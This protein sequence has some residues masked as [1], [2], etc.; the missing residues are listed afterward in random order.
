[1]DLSGLIDRNAA[2]APDKPAIRCAGTT[3]TYADFAVRIA[4]A[5]R[6]LK[7]ELGIGRG[8]RVAI[9]SLNHPDYLVLLYACA[10]LGAMLVPLNWRL[11]VPEQVFILSDASVKAL[12]VEQDSAAVIAPLAQ[13]LP[14]AR[15]VGL[16]FTPDGGV[17]LDTL[18][19]SGTGD[20]RNPHV[21]LTSPL[22]IV[23]T[24]GTTGR[25]KGAVL[26]QEALVWNA[27]M[28]Q[29]MHD[30]TAADHV[31][32][33]LP[34]FHV[35][36]LN[37]QTTPALQLGATVTLH[38]R[39]APDATLDAL[40]RDKPTLTVLV[41]ATMQA[42]IEHPRWSGTDISSLRALT[43]GSTQVPQG[44]ADAFTKRNI[45]VL[46]VYGSTETCPLAVYTRLNGDQRD[47]STG[48]PGLVCDARIVND[49][50]D[51]VAA[52]VAGEVIV[53]GPNVFFEYWGHAA[54]T[55]EALREGWYYSG[56][57]GTR[58]ADGHFFIHDR[59][60]NMIISGGEN[61]Y[62][63]EIE[64]VLIAHPDVAEAAVIGRV[65]PKWQEVPV[66]YVVRRIGCV[67]NARA[68]EAH[69]LGQLARFK[70]P[71]EYVF[72][73]SLPRNAMGKVQHFRLREMERA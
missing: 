51:E 7:S 56:D 58:D 28:S 63:A 36:G 73:E 47:G 34:L 68:L 45:P 13:A 5:A 17:S 55:T 72:V 60:K 67:I 10:R 1:M 59:K 53:R 31:L 43:T 20:S 35:G 48:L 3:L 44:L 9:L 19:T 64:R 2:F 30:M 29:H 27:V 15:I 11:A 21:D 61:I 25:P 37:I 41:P 54:A 57:I 24:S 18:L 42:V 26:R 4:T 49:D 6:A 32:T 62:P 16:D 52:G 46:Q 12:V 14:D 8:D 39:F 70:V 33:V 69:L 40:A 66:A 23:Y 71:R 65:D 38:P 22:L 50:G